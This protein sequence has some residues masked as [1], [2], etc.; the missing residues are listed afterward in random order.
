MTDGAVRVLVVDDHRAF[1]LAARAVVGRVDGFVVVAEAASGE[2]AVELAARE[3]PALVLMDITMPGIGGVEA[4]R[5][6]LAADASVRVV[7]C[8]TY[9][10]ADLPAAV[11][12][13][14]APYVHKEELS[15]A[16]LRRLWDESR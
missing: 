13:L 2:E 8:S 7:L 15:P 1:R 4:A 3:H 10:R 5:R 11:A 9:D 14:G 12:E 16:V 6:I